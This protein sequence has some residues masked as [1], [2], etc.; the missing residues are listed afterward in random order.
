MH[1]TSRSTSY[2]ARGRG[3]LAN[4]TDRS[5]SA[6]AKRWGLEVLPTNA[7]ELDAGMRYITFG[8]GDDSN[9]AN[10]EAWQGP[11]NER[12]LPPDFAPAPTL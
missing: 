12:G 10:P 11:G 9:R 8:L 6:N 1:S 2:A 3:G 7:N 4:N 5:R